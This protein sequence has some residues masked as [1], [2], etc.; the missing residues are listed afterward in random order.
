[1]DSADMDSERRSIVLRYYG[2][3]VCST[4]LRSPRGCIFPL[5]LRSPCPPM[6]LPFF[7]DF[8]NAA[9]SMRDPR[10]R[11]LRSELIPCLQHAGVLLYLPTATLVSPFLQCLV[12][13]Q[14]P[15]C[16]CF[17]RCCS[18]PCMPCAADSM[19]RGRFY[20]ACIWSYTVDETIF[21]SA[22]VHHTT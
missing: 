11:G 10:R 16:G 9:E 20:D 18:A 2:T 4:G 13:S 21:R 8:R 5:G 14:T 15:G 7:V 6:D 1:M 3:T 17:G 12:T 22:F 19:P